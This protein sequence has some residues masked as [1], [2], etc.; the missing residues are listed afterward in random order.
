[1][2]LSLKELVRIGETQL[3]NAGVADASIDA[4]ELFCF[5][6]NIDRSRL[7][8]RWQDILQ[9]N[10][11]DAYFDLIAERASRKPLQHITGTQEFMGYTF[12]VSKDALIPRQDT[13]TMVEDA[14]EIIQ[15]N[16][17]RGEKLTARAKDGW[18]VLDLCCGSGAI[19][20][21]MALSQGDIKVTCADISQDALKLAQ[22]NGADLGCKSVKFVKSNMFDAFRGKRDN[23][24]FDMI[25]SNPPYIKRDVIPTLEPEVK[26]HEPLVA[27]DGGEDGLDFYRIIAGEAPN[28]LKKNGVVIVDIGHDQMAQVM[29]LFA[30]SDKFG[31]VTGLKDLAGRD[32]IVVA[33]A[34]PPKSRKELRH[35]KKMAKAEEKQLKKKENLQNL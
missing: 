6:F 22:K 3:A 23:K 13:E 5:L 21:S 28:F 20:I 19:G 12:E 18:N 30:K 34:A 15:K 4:R 29:A 32:R 11:C 7:M 2:S 17:L 1:M 24:R 33:V 35:E 10:Q 16:S 25:I 8:L 9:D 27:L 14:L 26:D 31:Y